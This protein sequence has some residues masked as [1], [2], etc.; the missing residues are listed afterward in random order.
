MATRNFEFKPLAEPNSIRILYLFPGQNED[1]LL[2]HIQH[3]TLAANTSYEALSYEW[4]SPEKIHI[5]QLENES[6]IR[7]TESLHHALRDL[8]PETFEQQPRAIWADGIC[9]NQADTHEVEQQVAIMGDIYRKASRV[10][11]Y[12]GPEKDDGSIAVDFAKYLDNYAISKARVP[13]PPL[14]LTDRL[15]EVGLPPISDPRWPALRALLLRGWASRCWCAHEFLLNKKLIMMVGRRILHHWDLLPNIV[16]LVFSRQLP[17]YL[18]PG[19][20]EDPYALAECLA[21]LSHLRE[22]IWIDGLRFDL[23]TLLQF[24]HPFRASNPRDKVYSI[25]GL[26][27]DRQDFDIQ[28]DYDRPVVDLYTEV[29]GRIFLKNQDLEFLSDVFFPKSIPGLPSWVADWS[30]WVYGSQGVMYDEIYSAGGEST[31]CCKLQVHF[32]EAR[33]DVGGYF[34]GSIS[35]LGGQILPHYRRVHPDD[36]NDRMSWLQE[37]M[38]LVQQLSPYPSGDDII[39]V[40]WRT[41]IGNLTFGQCRA[42]ANYR[43]YFEAHLKLGGEISDKEKDLAGEFIDAVRRKSR[44]RRLAA[45]STGHLGAVPEVANEGD[46]ICAFSGARHLFVVRDSGKDDGHFEFVG[47]AY[48]HGL[49][50]GEVMRDGRF[51]EM[52]ISLV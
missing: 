50:D 47:S 1:V 31:T 3:V 27:R 40:F 46:F 10:V 29:S 37:Q 18:L 14:H 19:P 43:E 28:V 35:K 13:D 8:R 45:I 44:T 51:E 38:E 34:I 7:I 30:T 11:T 41:L 20:V 15:E 42:D 5:L 2:G 39:D 33:L 22:L 32:A 49:M 52:T 12:T 25:L 9:I 6:V 4:G 26:A 24:S 17:V 16:E 36:I 21:T 48:V 23:G